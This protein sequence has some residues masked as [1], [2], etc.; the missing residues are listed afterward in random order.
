M[1]TR[2]R[3][4]LYTVLL[5]ILCLLGC[6]DSGKSAKVLRVGF[7]PAEDAQQVMQNAQ[8]IVDILQK[9]LGMEIQ[10]FVAAD[11]TGVVEALRVNKLDVA[12]L[13]PASYVLAKNEANV[14]VVLKSERKGIASYYAAIITRAD[15]GIQRLEDLRGKTFAFGDALSTTGNIFPRKM[16]KERG[17]D[18]VRDFKQILY[19]GGHDAT[20]LAVLNGKVDAG[21]T[22][23]NS[24]DGDDTAWMRYLKNPEDVN[25][26][27]AIA[28]SEPIPA[29]N[30]VINGNLD[31]AVAKKVEEIFLQL[32][33]DPKGKQMMRD[34]YQ[35]D[36][37]VP[38]TDRDYDSVRQAFD[39]AGIPLK[40]SLQRKQP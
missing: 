23:A 38:A 30:L 9:Q 11:Y 36:G 24:P 5:I 34:L 19:S 13:T 37:F 28:F 3:P 21:A 14:K 22:Y 7:V 40:A 16:F 4:R 39:I 32:S 35:I 8:P 31:E 1:L 2:H 27:R 18:P 29:D 15:S 17:I 6:G 10:P 33:G 26:I 12:F 25:K 20:V